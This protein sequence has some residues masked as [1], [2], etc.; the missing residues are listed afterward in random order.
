MSQFVLGAFQI[1]TVQ[2][3]ISYLAPVPFNYLLAHSLT[4]SATLRLQF[5]NKKKTP[6]QNSLLVLSMYSEQILN[7]T[8][9]VCLCHSGLT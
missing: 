6:H 4:P 9:K 2:V 5:S 8:Y 1:S 3:D 7:W